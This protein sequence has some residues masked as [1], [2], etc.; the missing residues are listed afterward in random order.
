[1]NN[2]TVSLLS[3][4]AGCVAPD[5][6]D[7]FREC[8]AREVLLNSEAVYLCQLLLLRDGVDVPL[9]YSTAVNLILCYQ[10]LGY[11]I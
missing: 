6:K 10:S 7:F 9:L 4:T 3:V 2:I 8:R 1:M 11:E 5:P